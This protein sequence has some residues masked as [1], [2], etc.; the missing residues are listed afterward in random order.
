M[1]SRYAELYDLCFSGHSFPSFH[2]QS[3]LDA[4][5]TLKEIRISWSVSQTYK[6]LLSGRYGWYLSHPDFLA[7]TT[8][9]SGLDCV[10]LRSTS[11]PTIACGG[12]GIRGLRLFGCLRVVI[13]LS[14]SS[15]G[16]QVVSLWVLGKSSGAF[17]LCL[18]VLLVSMDSICR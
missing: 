16:P 14:Y 1:L 18:V 12:A 9:L 2:Q 7:V 13:S 17:R 11:M 6:D 3:L 8:G 4:P 15:K 5:L 10:W